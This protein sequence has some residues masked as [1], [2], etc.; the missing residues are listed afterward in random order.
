MCA[1]K[2]SW[3]KFSV[4]NASHSLS[5]AHH[6]FRSACVRLHSALRSVS[7]A[8]SSA[9]HH[10]G[11]P[12]EQALLSN[13]AGR[14]LGVRVPFG[15]RLLPG[16][17]G[18]RPSQRAAVPSFGRGRPRTLA[19]GVLQPNL[20]VRRQLHGVQLRRVQVR[21]LRRQ[22]RGKTRVGSQKHLP[23]VHVRTAEVHLVP[24]PREDHHQPRLH[25]RDGHVRADEQRLDAHVRK[26]Q[27]VRPVRVDALLRVPR[28]AARGSWERVG[29]H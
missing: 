22:L 2:E 21:L 24:K 3:M 11:R 1:E 5:V 6:V 26:H 8:V 23:V 16:C 15:S 9:V 19:S 4:S 29:R 20:P 27:R 28:R 10:T 17:H 14:R 7:P 25:D 13:M 12:A 18:L